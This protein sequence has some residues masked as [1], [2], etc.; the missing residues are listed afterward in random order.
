MRK[1]RVQQLMAGTAIV[2][3]LALAGPFAPAL[4]QSQADIESR[5][6]MPEPA[7]VPPPTAADVQATPAATGPT[8]PAPTRPA[9][10]AAPVTPAQTQ[11]AAASAAPVAAPAQNTAQTPA[12]VAP[13]AATPVV[14]DS[15][16][17][18]RLREL[19]GGKKKDR[20]GV[21]AFYSARNFAPLWVSDGAANERAKAAI[22][23][24]AGVA[25]DGLNPADYPTPEFKAGMSADALADAELKLTNSVLT[26]AHHAQVGQVHYTR[27]S[28]DILYPLIAPE[29]H[30]VLE[31]VSTAS[32]VAAALDSFNPQ[33]P[34][35]KALKQ[36]LA[37]ARGQ[38]EDTRPA[39][40][41]SGPVLKFIKKQPMHDARVPQLRE[42]LSVA[43]DKSDTTYS[44]ELADAVA[45]FQ[46]AHDLNASGVL[47]PETLTAIN[48]PR[49]EHTVDIIIANMERLRWLPRDL[50]K[51]HV[52]VNIPDYTLT[53]F[54]NGKVYWKTKIVVGKP[55]KPTPMLTADM[56]FI[57]VNP[58]WN[59]PPS[60]I[61]NEY[62]PALQ[63]DPQALDRI[64]LKLT[65]DA[66]G[67]LHVS[68]PPGDRNALGRI[69][70]NF[71]NKFL[72]YQHDTPDK[73][74]FAKDKRAFSHGCMRVENP[75]MYGEKLLS[76]EL[77]EDHYTTAKL[78][79]MFGG[80]EI[81]INFPAPIPVHITYQT[82]FVDEDG[83]LQIRD[84][85]YGRDRQVLA[86]L[87]NNAERKVADIAI[88]RPSPHTSAK[89]V[90]LP[91]GT[92]GGP[93]GY[94][95]GPNFF[96]QLF[97][98]APRPPAPIASRRGRVSQR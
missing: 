35:Y 30:E 61:E 69:R 56:K 76:L 60:I 47:G 10:I 11:P 52:I 58:T 84:D 82:A 94:S 22:A 42:R 85:V 90:K 9:E 44:K 78:Q 91:P 4:A 23:Y 51:N 92:Y 1:V 41:P 57:T 40:I 16:V 75:L 8:M 95:S 20:N 65:Q 39:P 48:G 88:D 79:G 70:F 77:P 68:Q 97:G 26:F 49:R 12:A 66:D 27:V 29:P 98:L 81:N 34:E 13:A 37:E 3:G 15:A 53:L 24:L 17:G 50:G 71:P 83:K 62:L 73:Y 67:T 63:Q 5:V 86:I 96:E 80:S 87:N 45:K 18:D 28:A 72:V 19:T 59:V 38:T 32:N 55:D 6:P 54:H 36:K 89:P 25:A 93:T 21:E 33:I 64:G 43:G 14:A 74:L 46:K 7:N 2:F 31:K